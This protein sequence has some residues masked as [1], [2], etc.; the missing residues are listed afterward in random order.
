[1]DRVKIW[2]TAGIFGFLVGWGLVS[3]AGYDGAMFTGTLCA[4]VCVWVA[5]V[6]W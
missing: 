4:A 6:E 1:M 2:S 3:L 5:E